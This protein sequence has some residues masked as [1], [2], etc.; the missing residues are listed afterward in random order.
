MN[1]PR[2]NAYVRLDGE[3]RV[4]SGS[5]V[6]RKK[7][8]VTGHWMQIQAQQCCFPYTSLE[9]T[10][11]DVILSDIEF[12]I[13]CDD[14]PVS[15]TSLTSPV[16]TSIQDIVDTLNANLGYLGEFS[17]DG[18]SITLHLFQNIADSLCDGTLSIEVDGTPT[19][20]STTSTTTTTTTTIP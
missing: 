17:T 10:P 8:P 9:T 11:E 19:T 7:K 18:T 4:V 13:L 2:T 20:T 5:V 6:L 15:V 12:T 3:G 14:V 16:S 1:N